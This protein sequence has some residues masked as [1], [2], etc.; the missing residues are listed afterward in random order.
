VT[1]GRTAAA[2][3]SNICW[4]PDSLRLAVIG[5][6]EDD[7]H[8]KRPRMALNCS[9]VMARPREPRQFGSYPRTAQGFPGSWPALG[10][11]GLVL[12]HRALEVS[13][14]AHH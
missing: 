6:Q 8:Y 7:G 3:G 1:I 2:I 10:R 11:R 13:E 5:S 14:D 9:W 12:D 4:F